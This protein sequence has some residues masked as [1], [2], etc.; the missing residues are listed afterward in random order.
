MSSVT[1]FCSSVAASGAGDAD[2]GAVIEMGDRHLEFS[3]SSESALEIASAVENPS[4]LDAYR[5]N[6]KGDR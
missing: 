4:D 2:D 1:T 5:Q 6:S 3:S